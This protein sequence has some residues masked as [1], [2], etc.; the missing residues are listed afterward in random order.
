MLPTPSPPLRAPTPVHLDLPTWSELEVIVRSI[1][2]VLADST[3]TIDIVVA[4]EITAKAQVRYLR[5]EVL[6]KT[7][8]G[9]ALLHERPELGAIDLDALRRLPDGTFGREFARFLDA[10]GLDYNVDLEAPR[11][12]EDEDAHYV[13]RRYRKTHDIFHVLLGLGVEGH[14][15]VL[16]HAFTLAQMGMPSSVA[17]VVL[18]AMKHMVLEGRLDCLRKRLRAAF[19]AGRRAA[20]LLAVR[21]E[22]HFH[23]PLDEV[24]RRYA[25]VTL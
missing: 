25:I 10:H 7:D 22:S 9:R 16:V 3:K 15:E 12:I 4:E 14:E 5:D 20:P 24:R 21:F 8:E 19:D 2:R 6:C 18:G 23:E 11:Y 1:A 17:I 13:L